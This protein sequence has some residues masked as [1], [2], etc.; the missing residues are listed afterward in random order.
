MASR[1]LLPLVTLILLL[2][3]ASACGLESVSTF[4]AWDDEKYCSIAFSDSSHV[5]RCSGGCASTYKFKPVH[6]FSS[7]PQDSELSQEAQSTC[8]GAINCCREND[9]LTYHRSRF[10][11]TCLY[12]EDY[13]WRSY[14]WPSEFIYMPGSCTCTECYP[15]GSP[16]SAV[17]V[18]A[19]SPVTISASDC[20]K[21]LQY[22]N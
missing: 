17:H 9:Y 15:A 12:R 2:Q 14:T 10:N 18:P 8:E 22:T 20:K 4:Y 16:T 19:D 21:S 3:D 7:N 6:T 5:K 11:I 1:V 13:T